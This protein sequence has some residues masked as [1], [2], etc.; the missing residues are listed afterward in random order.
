MVNFLGDSGLEYPFERSPRVVGGLRPPFA[1]QHRLERSSQWYPIASD[2]EPSD[3]IYGDHRVC[4][5]EEA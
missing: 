1:N 3:L 4:A 2:N 5:S